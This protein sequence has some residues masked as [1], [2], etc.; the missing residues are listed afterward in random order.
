MNYENRII[1][2][3]DIL[4]FRSIIKATVDEQGSDVEARIDDVVEGI[5]RIE[6]T[7]NNESLVQLHTKSWVVT[8][9]SDSIVASCRIDEVSGVLDGLL[10]SMWACIRLV[11]N[12]M[13]PRGAITVGQ[14]VHTDRMMFGPAMVRA[15]DLETKEA[16]FPRIIVDDRVLEFAKRYYSLHHSGGDELKCIRA[17]LER[18]D[19]GYFFIDYV[20]KGRDEL[21]D[22]EY[23]Y[24]DFLDRIRDMAEAGLRV[25]SEDVREKYDWLAD[26]Y[27]RV[28]RMVT[29]PEFL[30]ELRDDGKSDL[31]ELY[32]GLVEIKR[33][34]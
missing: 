30:N 27:N 23:D 16:K 31:H 34:P 2:F 24:P 15:Y 18:D 4:G 12:G 7:F 5:R 29:M 10:H 26:R 32:S 6:D 19:D 14:L 1:V 9:F 13:L 21:D 17:L 8:Q 11:L 33:D 3:L 20:F 22:P 25:D 28:V